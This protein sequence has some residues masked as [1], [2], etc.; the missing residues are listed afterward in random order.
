MDVIERR[1]HDLLQPIKYFFFR[2][3]LVA[4]VLTPF[5]IAHH[6]AACVGKNIG[7]D[8]NVPL[9][10]NVISLCGERGIREFEDDPCLYVMGIIRVDLVREGLPYQDFTVN[11]KKLCRGNGFSSFEADN[12]A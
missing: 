10:E 1:G 11:G 4:E 2:P 9:V 8:Q 6:N 3:N 12:A 7:N 5:E